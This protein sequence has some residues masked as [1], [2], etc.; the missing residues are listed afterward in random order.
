MRLSPIKNIFIPYAPG[1]GGG[2]IGAALYALKKNKK[3]ISQNSVQYNLLQQ[4]HL[5]YPGM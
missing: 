1:D 3:I 4:G 2:S 5:A